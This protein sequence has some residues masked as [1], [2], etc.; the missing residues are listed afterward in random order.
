M[1]GVLLILVGMWYVMLTRPQETPLQQLSA[2]RPL[3]Q[4]EDY[5]APGNGRAPLPPRGAE[6]S[7]FVTLHRNAYEH[8]DVTTFWFFESQEA[9]LPVKQSCVFFLPASPDGLAA[10]E[11][12][13]SFEIE[14]RPG[15]R[16]TNP[17]YMATGLTLTEWNQAAEV[18]RWHDGAQPSR[19]PEAPSRHPEAPLSRRT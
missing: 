19:R 10:S 13:R 6:G 5:L 18:C 3:P 9:S 14:Q 17:G 11:R 2:G 1:I 8:G 7:V 16:Q 4:K 15:G 12:R